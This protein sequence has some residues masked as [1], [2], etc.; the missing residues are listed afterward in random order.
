MGLGWEI[1]K[2]RIMKKRHSNI[3][4]IFNTGEMLYHLKV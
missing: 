4:D 1:S 2:N 3:K